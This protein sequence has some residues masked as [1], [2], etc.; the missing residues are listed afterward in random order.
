MCD[1]ARFKSSTIAIG[2]LC[3]LILVSM[4][5]IIPFTLSIM[6][7]Y[8]KRQAHLTSRIAMFKTGF[9]YFITTILF[10]L[11]YCG[12]LFNDC[13]GC[14]NYDYIF[15]CTNAIF[16]GLHFVLL[17]YLLVTRIYFIFRD[18]AYRLSI[19]T[20]SVFIGLTVFVAF[21][22]I[23][24]VLIIIITHDTNSVMTTNDKEHLLIFAT[25]TI[26]IA[27]IILLTICST[28]LYIY[29]LF[30]I[31]YKNRSNDS[32]IQLK[33]DK[34]V[35]SIT[36][37]TNLAVIWISTSILFWCI[38][39]TVNQF[40]YNIYLIIYYL[41]ILLDVAANTIAFA[42]GYQFADKLYTKVCSYSDHLLK[43]IFICLIQ[44]K[45]DPLTKN[46]IVLA[47]C[48]NAIYTEKNIDLKTIKMKQLPVETP[49][50]TPMDTQIQFTD[51]YAHVTD[52]IL[53][54]NI[55]GTIFGNNNKK[56]N[57]SLTSASAQLPT[58]N[59]QKSKLKLSMLSLSA[60]SAG[61]KEN[62]LT[63]S[64]I[65]DDGILIYNNELIN[66]QSLP[67][68]NEKANEIKLE[69]IRSSTIPE[70]K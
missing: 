29:K 26:G 60:V 47:Q 2:I 24:Y 6:Y 10:C 17:V 14:R 28:L 42:L 69:H 16:Y 57:L 31:I 49:M 54:T 50:E 59:K 58:D 9:F 18:S 45:R 67:P 65:D 46:E 68:L 8:Y 34:L 5:I 52:T 33:N 36:K 62:N 19:L 7:S 37:Y 64:L 1:P 66:I 41:F 30:Q 15:V 43:K 13:F 44:T 56:L 12:M 55:S 22:M 23:L 70:N 25:Y 40:D 38:P 63:N 4:L 20:I 27:T 11:N 48:V 53:E 3:T 32:K 61:N 39:Y 21:D 51:A 35:K